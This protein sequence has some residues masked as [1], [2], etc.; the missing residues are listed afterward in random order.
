MAQAGLRSSLWADG[1]WLLM[2]PISALLNNM[3]DS[4][5]RN[6]F[7]SLIWD[8]AAGQWGRDRLRN[9]RQQG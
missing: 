3:F 7:L 9:D 4:K 6:A 5:Q 2:P 8:C 1:P